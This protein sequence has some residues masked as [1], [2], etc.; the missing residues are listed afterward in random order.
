MIETGTTSIAS[1]AERLRL[2]LMLCLFAVISGP[3]WTVFVLSIDA[4]TSATGV[5]AGFLGGVL[6]AIAAHRK[7]RI[8]ATHIWLIS[9]LTA[10]SIASAAMEHSSNVKAFF[11]HWLWVR[12]CYLMMRKK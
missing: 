2:V 5:F 9:A 4:P 6:G 12:S 11:R 3:F 7:K 8:L 10:V 1:D